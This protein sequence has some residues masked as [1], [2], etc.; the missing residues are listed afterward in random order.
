ML[1]CLVFVQSPGQMQQI[2]NHNC[3]SSQDHRSKLDA[4]LHHKSSAAKLF[5]HDAL[6][7][8]HGDGGSGKLQNPDGPGCRAGS[9][10]GCIKGLKA[11]PVQ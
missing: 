5:Y 2:H 6:Q 9:L 1:S 7:G 11:D 4:Y 10:A 8:K 3:K